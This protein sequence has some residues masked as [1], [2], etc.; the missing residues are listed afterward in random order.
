[1]SPA[2]NT[3][4]ASVDVETSKQQR[5]G[6]CCA[7]ETDVFPR[8]GPLK[9]GGSTE[10]KR[11]VVQL[12]KGSGEEQSCIGGSGLWGWNGRRCRIK[13]RGYRSGDRLELYERLTSSR[14]ESS[15]QEAIH[16]EGRGAA[17]HEVG[18]PTD[19]SGENAEGLGATVFGAE[20]IDAALAGRV[21]LQKEDSGLGVGPLEMRVSDLGPGG[22]GDPPCGGLL[23]LHQAGIGEE[24]LDTGK[25]LDVV[26]L[27]KE[28][29][30]EDR[31]DAGDGLEKFEGVWRLDPGPLTYG[32]LK[33][34][35]DL[36]ELLGEG[37]IGLDVGAYDGIGHG[38]GQAAAIRRMMKGGMHRYMVRA[39]RSMPQ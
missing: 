5:R 8:A 11:T 10:E 24:V 9:E 17:E 32:L 12:W 35:D 22:S 26:E 37:E 15:V 1:M 19:A 27:V 18:S 31:P 7:L 14:P 3:Y 34:G 20:P 29:E 16:V 6:Q 38:L 33:R 39:C 4:R 23:A 2:P 30:G 21:L 25:A 36:V 28:R 13:Q